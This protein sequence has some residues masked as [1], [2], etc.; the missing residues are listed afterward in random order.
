MILTPNYDLRPFQQEMVKKFQNPKWPNVL[1]GDDM[2]LGKT[3]EA[4][5]LD[6]VKRLT[7]IGPK[8][9]GPEKPGVISGGAKTLV[10]SPLTPL[11]S[12]EDHYSWTLPELKVCTIDPKNRGAFL[13]AVE[14]GKHD[15]YLMHW[16][17]L[18]LMPELGAVDWFHVIGDEIHKIKNRKA[19]VTHALKK[20]RTAHKL[21]LS[22]TPADNHPEDLWSI[23]NWLYPKLFGSYWKFFKMYVDYDNDV[24]G[25]RVVNGV[26][27][28]VHLQRTIEPFF[29]RR[30]KEEVLTDLP[31]KYYTQ[32]WVDLTPQQRKAY[33]QMRKH[34]L[35]WVGENQEKPLAAPVAVTQLL[36]LQQFAL[37]TIDTERYTKRTRNKKYNPELVKSYYDEYGPYAPVPEELKIQFTRYFE[38]PNA[39]R[40][41][42]LE[43]SSKIDALMNIVEDMDDENSLV[44]FTYFKG[45]VD[46][47]CKRLA[48]KGVE[49]GYITGD[50]PKSDRDNMVREFQAGVRKVL[51]G[52]IGAMREGV[53][54]TRASTVVFLD[55]AWSPSWN[56][57]AEDRLHRIGQK[58]AVNV[59][60]IMAR[61]TVDLGRKQKVELKWTWIQKLLGDK[62]LDYQ[63][64]MNEHEF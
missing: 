1:C 14:Q 64:E 8:F 17:A 39:L 40:Y 2:G 22:G 3:L 9:L 7:A 25:Y 4:I 55:R 29:I 52:T 28:A 42:L 48:N 6:R 27:N 54:L 33:D 36:R 23:L 46:L 16:D 5:D 35:S 10:L 60:D 18:R 62:T 13:R 20:L 24:R 38:D 19:Q 58:N 50:V 15:I 59:I 44:V 45:A 61:N 41:L 56:R 21:G 57:Q 47:V 37:A 63:K 34:M 12:W 53:T 11:G 49:Y 31:D 51:V 26:R 32:V 43:P 30:R